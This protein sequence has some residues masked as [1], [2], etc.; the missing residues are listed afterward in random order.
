MPA[1]KPVPDNYPRV[2]PYLAIDGAAAAIEFYTSV[3][4]ARQRGGVM[5]GPDGRIGHAELVLGDSVIM[6]ADEYPEIGSRA[7]KTIGGT[8]VLLQVYVEDVDAVFAKALAAGAIEL[9]PLADQFYGDRSG[10]FEDPFGH[11]WNVASHIEDV[12]PQEMASRA[13]TAMGGS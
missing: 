6:L 1:V 11:R 12:P 7:P 3:F 10:T 13:A 8:P 5:T 9:R 4:G 2:S